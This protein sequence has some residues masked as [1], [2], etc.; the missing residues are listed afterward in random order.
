MRQYKVTRRFNIG[1]FLAGII[2]AGLIAAQFEILN[3]VGTGVIIVGLAEIIT[4]KWEL[5]KEDE[6]V[7][8]KE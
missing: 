5:V 4:Y 3:T 8:S 6:N 7:T 2:L 1:F